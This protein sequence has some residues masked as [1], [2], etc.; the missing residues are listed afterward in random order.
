VDNIKIDLRE[1]SYVHGRQLHVPQDHVQWHVL[2]L[3]WLR[4]RVTIILLVSKFQ[5]N[6]KM[7]HFVQSQCTHFRHPAEHDYK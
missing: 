5:T 3:V 1:R 6:D 7:Y 2:A 4:F